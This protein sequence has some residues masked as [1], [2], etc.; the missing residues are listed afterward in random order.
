MSTDIQAPKFFTCAD[1][2]AQP[3]LI[4]SFMIDERKVNL[5][6]LLLYTVQRLN[7]QKWLV[8]N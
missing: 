4:E 2:G 8:M 6:L 1:N 5:D 3:T 7:G